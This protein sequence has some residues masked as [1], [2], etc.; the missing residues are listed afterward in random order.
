MSLFFNMLSKLVIA[1]LP[2]SKHLL[3]SW[4][5]SPFAVILEPKISLSLFPLFP[6]LFVMRWWDRMTLVFWMLSLK[7]TFLLFSFT[8]IKRLFSYLNNWKERVAQ[9][10]TRICISNKVQLYLLLHLIY[11]YWIDVQLFGYFTGWISNISFYTYCIYSDITGWFW[12][13]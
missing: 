3:I 13:S 7:P 5:Q 8:F 1:F 12:D 2:K 10:I 6:H 9:N 4:L 11:N